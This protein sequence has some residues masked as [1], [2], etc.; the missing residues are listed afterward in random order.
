[1]NTSS[2]QVIIVDDNVSYREGLKYMLDF[3]KDF[4]CQACYV[5]GK[6]LI[7]NLPTPAPDVIL[8]DIEMPGLDGISATARIKSNPD[9]A[10]TNIIVLSVLQNTEKVMDAILA[11]ASGY[12]VKS[13]APENILT[14]I[15]Q[16]HLGGSPMSS[17]I[18]RKVL[19][20]VRQSNQ[21]QQTKVELNDRE[22]AVLTGLVDGLSY[23]MIGDRNAMATDT[24][25]GYIKR[26]YEKLQVHSRSE[27]ITKALR[28]NIL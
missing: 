9:Y 18:A 14:A 12:L 13:E 17:E 25:R 8:M 11:G 22:L 26:I 2:I 1:L 5:S 19:D 20:R 21:Q 7:D 10:S 28:N 23:K 24:V 4:H 27:A 15:R 16:V 6:D 3:S